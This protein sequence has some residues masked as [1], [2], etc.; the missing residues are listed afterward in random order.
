MGIMYMKYEIL[1]NYF[2]N[3]TIAEIDD[4]SSYI[5]RPIKV[6]NRQPAYFVI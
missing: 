6:K 5:Y 4:E 1:K 2:R 3:I